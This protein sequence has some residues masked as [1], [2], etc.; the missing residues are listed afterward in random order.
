MSLCVIYVAYDTNKTFYVRFSPPLAKND[1]RLKKMEHEKHDHYLLAHP[2]V[3]HK[4][5]KLKK[6]TEVLERK[7]WFCV[8]VI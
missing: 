4:S 8:F 2:K 3:S 5:E 1:F 7:Q 6:F